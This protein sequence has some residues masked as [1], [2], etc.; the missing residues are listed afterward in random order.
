MSQTK[1][2]KPAIHTRIFIHT[3]PLKFI[4]ICPS[5]GPKALLFIRDNNKASKKNYNPSQENYT[6]YICIYLPAYNI[7]Q[8]NQNM[9]IQSPKAQLL[10]KI[11]MRPVKNTSTH[12]NNIRYTHKHLYNCIKHHPNQS[13]TTH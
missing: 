7:T 1:L 3:A 10:K 9:P 11:I 13:K 6:I 4:R 8:T 2:I 5:K 12:C